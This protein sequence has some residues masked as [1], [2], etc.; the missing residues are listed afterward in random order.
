[1]AKEAFI[2]RAENA[3]AILDRNL[4]VG[5]S[6]SSRMTMR[7][8]DVVCCIALPFVW[9]VALPYLVGRALLNTIVTLQISRLS[10]ANVEAIASELGNGEK[11]KANFFWPGRLTQIVAQERGRRLRRSFTRLFASAR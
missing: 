2:T 4:I 5:K 9:K 10:D 3:Q 1:M 11:L 6:T 7:A 8:V